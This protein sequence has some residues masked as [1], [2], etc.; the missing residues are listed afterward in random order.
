MSE[1]TTHSGGCQCGRVRYDVRLDLSKPV[2]SCNC[3]MCGR[4]GTLLAFV[5]A[6]QFTLRSGEDVLTDYQFNNHIIHHLFGQCRRVHE[7]RVLPAGFGYQRNDRACAVRKRSR[8]DLRCRRG[9]SHYD[10][11]DSLV[12]NE[13]RT[14][15]FAC[16]RK[17]MKRVNRDAGV[18]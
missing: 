10:P 14:D 15:D 7:H 12:R 5:P 13:G 8:D 1:S 2:I 16:A 9:A 4:A 3:S 6:D 17:K 11:G 18:V